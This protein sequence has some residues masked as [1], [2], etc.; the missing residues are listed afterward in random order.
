VPRLP[1]FLLVEP[2]SVNHCVWQTHDH[3]RLLDHP[4]AKEKFLAL[5]LRHKAAHGILI[6][7]YCLMGTHPHVVCAA[8]LGQERFSA[9]WKVVNH[10]FAWWLNRQL[11]RRGQV[12]MERL[13]SPRLQPDGPHVLRAMRYGDR[14][15]VRAGLCRRPKDWKWSSH[16]HY[17]F[18]E[19]DLVVDD[20]PSYLALGRT[21]AERR[22]AYQQFDRLPVEDLDRRD[23]PTLGRR[24]FVGDTPWVTDRY[25][26]AGLDPPLAAGGSALRRR[27][28]APSA[29]THS[30]ST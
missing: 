24:P 5:L 14:N 11:G 8:T 2:G 22:R 1:R 27:T 23:R 4:G 20:A 15:P 26:D 9:F 25:V 13:G 6:H 3:Q 30:T 16:R 12:V 10:A 28:L 21:S 19:P 7:S 18:G 29:S 17:A